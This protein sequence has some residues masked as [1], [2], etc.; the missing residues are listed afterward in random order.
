MKDRI[1]AAQAGHALLKRKSDAIKIKLQEVLGKIK[2]IKREVNKGMT[3]AGNAHTEALWTAGSFNHKVIEAA[4]QA[5]FRVQA[6]LINVAG[7]KIPRFSRAYH[8]N[9]TRTSIPSLL[10]SFFFSFLFS[11]EIIYIYI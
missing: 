6:D 11:I 7:V 5:S 10:P 8:D 9:N 1:K 4:D 2:N 3:E